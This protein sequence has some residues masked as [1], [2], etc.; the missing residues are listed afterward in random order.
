M[1]DPNVLAGDLEIC[2]AGTRSAF[3]ILISDLEKRSTHL[4][5]YS[6][7]IATVPLIHMVST[8]SIS[9][10]GPYPCD[11]HTSLRHTYPLI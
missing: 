1:D 6:L 4:G 8:A 11:L 5:D 2:S 3:G 7:A 9:I 10:L